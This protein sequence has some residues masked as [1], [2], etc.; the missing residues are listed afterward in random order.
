[1]ELRDFGA[2]KEWPFCVELK[3]CVELRDFGCRKGV[4]LVWN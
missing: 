2:E 3:E 1:M 4:V